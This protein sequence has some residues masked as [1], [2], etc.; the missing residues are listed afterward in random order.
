MAL[1]PQ[2]L[3]APG[4]EA[5]DASASFA[6]RA[7]QADAWERA[8]QEAL[9]DPGP[10]WREW[11][12]YS[13]SKAWVALGF[14][15]VDIW[16]ALSWLD[17]FNGLGLGLSLAAAVYLEFLAYRFLWYHRDPEEPRGPQPFR[18]TWL[19]PREFGRWTREAALAKAGK[20]PDGSTRA[21]RREEFL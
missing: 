11:F 14:F 17:P 8:K 5:A 10:T 16:I 21:P 4:A 15:I 9:N 13:G 1:D 18:P 3:N 6:A 20:L 19:R 7:E 12:L 2:D